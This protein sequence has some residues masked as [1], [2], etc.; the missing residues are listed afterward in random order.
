MLNSDSFK[1]DYLW[2]DY[3]YCYFIFYLLKK[4]NFYRLPNKEE[5][6]L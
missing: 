6:K 4:E 2:S 5:K 1:D 3:C